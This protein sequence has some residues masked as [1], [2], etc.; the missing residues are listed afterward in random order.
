MSLLLPLSAPLRRVLELCAA[1]A[2]PVIREGLT[3]ALAQAALLTELVLVP[4][5][6][7]VIAR[8]IAT[9][10]ALPPLFD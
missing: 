9:A 7:A 2:G 8:H 4:W 6:V 3:A 5:V 10:L 1:T